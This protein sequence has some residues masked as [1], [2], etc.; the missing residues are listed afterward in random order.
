MSGEETQSLVGRKDLG[1]PGRYVIKL[2][3][4]EIKDLAREYAQRLGDHAF[5]RG[6][7]RAMEREE[8]TVQKRRTRTKARQNG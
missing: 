2:V 8:Q 5:L 7:Q 4:Q 1:S 3:V 6:V